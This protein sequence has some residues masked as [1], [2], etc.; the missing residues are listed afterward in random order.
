MM[1]MDIYAMPTTNTD[2]S[3]HI[4]AIEFDQSYESISH[5]IPPLVIN[6]LGGEHTHMQKHTHTHTHTDVS[7]ETIL[8]KQVCTG[9]C[10]HTPG[11]KI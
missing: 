2:Y 6:S 11:L 1:R 4:K 5:H 10:Q 8:R 3:C 9:H 7:T